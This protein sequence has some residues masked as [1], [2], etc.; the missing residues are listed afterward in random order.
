MAALAGFGAPMEVKAPKAP[1]ALFPKTVVEEPGDFPCLKSPPFTKKD[2]ELIDMQHQLRA[3]YKIS[4]YHTK[5]ATQEKD[6]VRY[7]DA[8]KRNEEEQL[9][10]L[11]HTRSRYLPRELRAAPL[12]T[13]T[14]L[15]GDGFMMDIETLL[16]G[17]SG[18]P[19]LQS[20]LHSVAAAGMPAE[21]TRTSDSAAKRKRADDGHGKDSKQQQ[22]KMKKEETTETKKK[23]K[24][25]GGKDSEEE[26][27]TSSSS[28]ELDFANLIKHKLVDLRNFCREKGIAVR[29]RNKQGYV[30]AIEAWQKQQPKPSAAAKRTEAAKAAATATAA[31]PPSEKPAATQDKGKEKVGD[32]APTTKAGEAEANGGKLPRPLD[33]ITRL[34]LLEEE[35]AEEDEEEQERNKSRVLNEDDEEDENDYNER[36]DSEAEEED[37][38]DDDNEPTF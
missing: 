19:P 5:P 36:Y 1:P 30:D 3:I 34:A 22:K 27:A 26:N 15:E 11:L 38:D 31:A 37:D 20:T 7:S 24:T 17:V 8:L 28:T 4:P 12:E 6:V 18:V 29:S 25:A 13:N 14:S 35:G 23:K 2:K 16:S 33:R 10:L 9:D 21:L 32:A